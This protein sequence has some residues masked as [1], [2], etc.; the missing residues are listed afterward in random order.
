MFLKD[1]VEIFYDDLI[2]YYSKIIFTDKNLKIVALET[3]KI[4][5]KEILF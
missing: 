1:I 2:K 5:K 3:R 4:L